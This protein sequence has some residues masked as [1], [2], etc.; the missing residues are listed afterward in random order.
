M[1]KRW[2][3]AEMDFYQGKYGSAVDEIRSLVDDEGEKNKLLFLMEAGVIL[4]TIGEYEK[5][6]IAFKQADDMAERIKTSISKQALSFL[7]SDRQA[8]FKGENF[9]RVLIK[10]YMALNY[11]MLGDY[12]SAKRSFRKLDYDLKYM[13]YEDDRY[14]QNVAARF[15]D[16]VISESL[17]KY[18][19]ARV[20]YRNIKKINPHNKSILPSQYI[21]A[22]KEKDSGD[23][24]KYKK[25]RKGVLAFNKEMKPKKYSPDMGELIII[26]QA[27][28]SPAKRSRGSLGKDGVFIVAL[29][30]AIHVAIVAEGAAVSTSG[31]M[32][33]MTTA[34]NPIPIYKKRDIRGAKRIEVLVNSVPIGKTEIMND[35]EQTALKNFND[36]YSG[37]IVKNVASIATK[38]VLAAIAADKL[39]DQ[40]EKASGGGFLASKVTRFLIGAG[41][42]AAVAATV[43]PDLRC[44]RLL[45]AN[46]QIKRIFLEPG[47][48]K[49][50]FRFSNRDVITSNI[51]QNIV[52]KKAQPTF[53]NF[54]SMSELE[55]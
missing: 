13:K 17:G 9:E 16:A 4:H 11:I 27:G 28:R 2:E 12:E 32:A 48:Y 53:I 39:S 40:A 6:N 8:N 29:R 46:Y 15:L 47:E 24:N 42:G 45:P 41:T 21:L 5:S 44:W 22:V 36:N 18:N 25:G 30:I 19:D 20:Q 10:F 33:M 14:K 31:V 3:S 38:I 43:V 50:Q 7:L 26:Y 55:K 51:P 54:R 34:E 52:I 23:M 49:V 1:Y 37:L 35:Y